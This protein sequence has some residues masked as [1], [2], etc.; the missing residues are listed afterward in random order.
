ML[1]LHHE[2]KNAAADAAPEA[3]ESLPLRTNVKR[4][5]LFLV[6]GAKRL[7][8]RTRAF[9][10][11]I[12]ADHLDD[13]VRRGDLLDVLCWNL[14]QLIFRSFGFRSDVKL[15]RRRGAFQRNEK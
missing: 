11:K 7:E 13:V 5:R 2:A 12:G 1:I 10:W 14:A 8:I 9:Q 3:V 15:T 6:K 4:G